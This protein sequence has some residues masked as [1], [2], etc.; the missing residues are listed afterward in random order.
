MIAASCVT[1]SVR[2]F[3]VTWLVRRY[4]PALLPVIERRLALAAGAVAA[5]LVL[6]FLGLR[7]LPSA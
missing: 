4:G 7:L 3:G 1:R 6:A 5:V 2:F